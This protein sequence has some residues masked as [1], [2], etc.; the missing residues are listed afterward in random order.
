MAIDPCTEYGLA[1]AVEDFVP[2]VLAGTGLIVLA[3]ALGKSLPAVRA[4]ALFGGIVVMLGGL[5]KAVWK[6]LVAGPCVEIP[7]LEQMLFPCLAV[8]FSALAW[9]LASVYVGKV[10]SWLPFALVPFVGACISGA[11]R[12]L[13]PMLAIAALAAVAV[14][15]I[16][17]MLAARHGDQVSRVLFIVYIVGTLVLPPLAARPHQTEAVQWAEQLTN[18]GV[19]LCFL[20][21]ALRLRGRLPRADRPSV[22]EGASIS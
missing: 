19:Q 15:A 17:S 21:G 2:V 6:L 10:V 12:N 22:P 16:A 9:A 3:N 18:T 8:G 4:G 11:A 14:G 13:T 7:I 20:I 1:L 5:G